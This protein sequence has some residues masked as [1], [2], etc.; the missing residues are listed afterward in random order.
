MSIGTGIHGLVYGEG[1]FPGAYDFGTFRQYL[2][3]AVDGHG[4]DGQGEVVGNL[5]GSFLETVQLSVGGAGTFGENDERHA[6][7][8]DFLGGG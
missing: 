2:V 1:D 8:E 7:G 3:R 6:A 4:Y 5:V